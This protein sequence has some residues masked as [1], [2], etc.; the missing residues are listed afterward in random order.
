VFWRDQN[1]YVIEENVLS[2]VSYILN[3]VLEDDLNLIQTRVWKLAASVSTW[4][5]IT[6]TVCFSLLSSLR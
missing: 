3:M 2:W 1:V 4:D 5:I 6:K